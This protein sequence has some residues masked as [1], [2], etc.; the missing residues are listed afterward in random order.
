M[1][2]ALSGALIP[3]GIVRYEDHSCGNS[4]LHSVLFEKERGRGIKAALAPDHLALPTQ[5]LQNTK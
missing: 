1:L 4:L 2:A 5:W 3:S